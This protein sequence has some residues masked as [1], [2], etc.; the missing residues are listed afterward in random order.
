[1]SVLGSIQNQVR[2]NV[3]EQRLYKKLKAY[4]I[5]HRK[6]GVEAILN[7][8]LHDLRSKVSGAYRISDNYIYVCENPYLKT[9]FKT[10]SL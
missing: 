6:T 3:K 2:D 7:K 5:Y 9:H 1:M 4:N 8:R 10:F